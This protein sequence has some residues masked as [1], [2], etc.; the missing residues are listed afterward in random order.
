MADAIKRIIAFD[1]HLK[2]Q[3]RAIVRRVCGEGLVAVGSR[4][5]GLRRALRQGDGARFCETLDNLSRRSRPLAA[6]VPRRRRRA[7]ERPF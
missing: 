3:D 6:G 1:S 7:K 2:K 5:R 4:A